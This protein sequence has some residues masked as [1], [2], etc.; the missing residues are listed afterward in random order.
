MAADNHTRRRDPVDEALREREDTR[1][2]RH[3]SSEQGT[4]GM[5]KPHEPVYP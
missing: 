4:L 3:W 2:P 1:L 5:L